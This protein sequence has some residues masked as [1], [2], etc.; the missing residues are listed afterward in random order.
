MITKE[1]LLNNGFNP[2]FDSSERIWSWDFDRIMYNIKEQTLYDSDEVYGRHIK[3]AVVKDIEQ[4]KD[5]I[6]NYFK[7]NIEENE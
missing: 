1:Q 4:L 3:L 5:L 7:I 6:W 2:W